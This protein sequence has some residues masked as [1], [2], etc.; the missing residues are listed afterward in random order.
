MVSMLTLSSYSFLEL[1]GASLYVYPNSLS[2]ALNHV[3]RQ[4]V[5]TSFMSAVSDDTEAASK[6]DEAAH[7]DELPRLRCAQR[8][9]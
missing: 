7:E 1:A 6:A 3:Q 2:P 8:L 5:K 9:P 4:P